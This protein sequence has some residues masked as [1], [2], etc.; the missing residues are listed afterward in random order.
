ML[1]LL[2]IPEGREQLHDLLFNFDGRISRAG[3][4]RACIAWVILLLLL[5]FVMIVLGSL[6][7]YLAVCVAL[8]AGV[9]MFNSQI[10]V[11]K[12]RLHDRDKSG[13][14]LLLFFLGPVILAAIAMLGGAIASVCDLA[15]L[16]VSVWTIVELGCRPGTT[17]PNRYGPDPL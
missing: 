9:L 10:A 11:S 16:A 4:W 15:A 13:W 7:P 5:L 14:W 3:Y 2:P 12:K 17:G 1:D 6:M 8:I